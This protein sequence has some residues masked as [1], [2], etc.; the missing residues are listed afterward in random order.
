MLVSDLVK[1]VLPRLA[2]AQAAGGISVYQAANS[3]QSMIYKNLLRSKSDLIAGGELDLFIPAYGRSASLPSDFVSMAERPHSIELSDEW[4]AGTVV[5]Y[6]NDTGDLVVDVTNSS[7]T[8]TLAAWYIAL[9]GVPGQPARNIGNSTTSLTAGT[10]NQT[11]VTQAGLGLTAGQYLIISSSSESSEDYGRRRLLQPNYLADDQEYHDHRWWD[12]YAYWGSSFE[13]P[14]CRPSTYKIV[15]TTLY[16]RPSCVV[17]LQIE[18]RYNQKPTDLTTSSQTILWNGLF[19]E[20][21]REGVVLII[22]KGI[23]IPEGSQE[24]MAL[25]D[26]EFNSVMITRK[27]LIPTVARTGRDGFM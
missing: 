11:L 3:I 9:A 21:F 25:F 14:T 8:D 19:D 15:G 18:G 6:D 2:R 17:D 5:T 23:S 13:Y 27:R 7:G 20:L 22:T 4:M 24:F 12:N 10:G 26:R 1:A 16:I